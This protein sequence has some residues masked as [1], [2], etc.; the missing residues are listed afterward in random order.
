MCINLEFMYV[1]SMYVIAG[2]FEKYKFI[3]LLLYYPSMLGLKFSKLKYTNII[4][5]PLRSRNA[6][7]CGKIKISDYLLPNI[8]FE[9]QFSTPESSR[10][11]FRLLSRI[12]NS[13]H[14]MQNVCFSHHNFIYKLHFICFHLYTLILVLAQHVQVCTLCI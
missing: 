9:R 5:V 11:V 8:I 1:N 14:H 12:S 4:T 7:F 13:T 2:N 3:N 10:R 6:M